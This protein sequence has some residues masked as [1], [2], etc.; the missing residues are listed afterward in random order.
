MLR[1]EFIDFEFVVWF[2]FNPGSE[3]MQSGFLRRLHSYSALFIKTI[4]FGSHG[5]KVNGN[6]SFRK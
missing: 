1:A 4:G 5:G 6:R 3:V 2:D